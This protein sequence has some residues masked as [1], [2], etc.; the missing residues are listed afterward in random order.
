[1]NKNKICINVGDYVE[2]VYGNVGYIK[3]VCTCN[4]CKERG[5]HE[6]I[7][8]FKDG[9]VYITKH[10]YENI[11]QN[12][13]RIGS[14]DLK[15]MREKKNVEIVESNDDIMESIKDVKITQVDSILL[16]CITDDENPAV[17]EIDTS[18]ASEVFIENTKDGNQ[19]SLTIHI[20]GDFSFVITG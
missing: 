11:E 5:F 7:V 2:D 16:N 8:Q 3:E 15:A 12:Y 10:M 17:M 18:K 1:M 6:P 14:Y 9:T 13:D 19:K 20:E 4:M